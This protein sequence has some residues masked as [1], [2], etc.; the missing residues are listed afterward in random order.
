MAKPI[1]LITTGKQR[2]PAIRAEI[3]TVSA[4]CNMQYVESVVR[5]GGA[6]VT[7]P[8]VADREAIRA[9][10]E[11]ADGVLLTGGGD[12][13]SLA[14]GEEPHPAGK[15]QDPIR[16]EME[17]EVTRLALEMSRP[18]L[19]ICRGAQLVNVALGGTL[20]QDIPSQVSDPLQHYYYPLEP[21]LTHT[22][23]IEA[24]SLLAR[25]LQTTSTAVNSYHHQTVKAVGRGLRINCRARDGVIEGV[26]SS[27]GQPVLAV[28]FHP[29]E[30]SAIYPRFQALFNW[31]VQEA[32]RAG[33]GL[34]Q[35]A[36]AAKARR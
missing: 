21:A 20:V 35:S 13:V 16:D 8:C 18:V 17:F 29:E 22:I 7:L 23:D 4:T 6:P 19:G 31:L 28:Q 26:E 14:Y 30:S 11:A 1:I 2:M 27:E 34:Q 10:V 24:D 9:A 25:V 3:Q 36:A 33:P 32:G 12:I 5:A 15:Y